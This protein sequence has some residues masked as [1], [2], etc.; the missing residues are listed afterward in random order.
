[1]S[2]VAI[3]ADDNQIFRNEWVSVKLGLV[4]I[5]ADVIGPANLAASLIEGADHSVA[6][7][8]DEQVPH[9]RGSGENS[10]SSV[11][12][13]QKLECMRG[14]GSRRLLNEHCS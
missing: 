5:L 4:A 2:H 11:K 9:D 1:V 12:L 13:P 8:N 3:R 7:A 6:G 14:R 10:P